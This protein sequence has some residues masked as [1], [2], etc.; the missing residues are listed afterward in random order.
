MIKLAI[1]RNGITLAA[2]AIVAWSFAAYGPDVFASPWIAV[3]ALLC[4]VLGLEWLQ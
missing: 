4:A 3:A 2:G 1:V